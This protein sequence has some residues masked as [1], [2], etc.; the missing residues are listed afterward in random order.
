[1]L[2]DFFEVIIGNKIFL[3]ALFSWF[4]AQSIKMIIGIVTNIN[5]IR[6]AREDITE[7]EK[8]RIGI[9]RNMMTN[10]LWKTGGMP[11]SHTSTS[12][13]LTLAIGFQEGFS[14]SVFIMAF[15]FTGIV[16]RDSFGVRLLAGKLAR[17]V[18]V[19]I[20]V[21]NINAKKQLEKLKIVEGHTFPE[22]F[23]GIILG[24]FVCITIFYV[25]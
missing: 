6:K 7:E 18:N 11:S 1:M 13:G 3:S 5:I 10:L 23:V 19:L 24:I 20:D 22:V 17:R 16:I 14:S 21:Y 12:T 4:F 9:L 2:I 25:F 8:E 15:F